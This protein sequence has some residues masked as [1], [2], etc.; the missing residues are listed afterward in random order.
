METQSYVRMET[1]RRLAREALAEV[2][3]EWKKD[4]PDFARA[5]GRLEVELRILLDALDDQDKSA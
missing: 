1:V 4:A 3:A 5:A 2:A